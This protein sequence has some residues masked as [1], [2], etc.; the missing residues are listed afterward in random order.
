[1]IMALTLV[2]TW[3]F[4]G[5]RQSI[6]AAVLAHAS[7]NAAGA[8]SGTLLP[9]QGEQVGMT[10]LGILVL[11]AVALVVLTRGRLA[12]TPESDES[13]GTTAPLNDNVA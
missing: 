9:N 13:K 7:F 6:L 3:I 1:L 4:N 12:Y 8:W 5:A 10:A 2:L 11:C